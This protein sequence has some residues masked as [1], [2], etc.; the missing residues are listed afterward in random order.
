MLTPIHGS[1]DYGWPY[2]MGIPPQPDPQFGKPASFCQSK[3]VAA[4]ALPAHMAPLGIRFYNGGGQLP[5]AFD[6]GVFLAMHGSQLHTPTYGYEVRFVSLRP[7]KMAARLSSI[8]H[9]L[10]HRAQILGPPRRRHLR[11]GPDDVH[12]RR[13]VRVVYRVTFE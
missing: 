7:G 3:E 2:C 5:R 8:H 6:Y 9:R 4:V 13:R 11:Q 12:Q 10:E 1:S